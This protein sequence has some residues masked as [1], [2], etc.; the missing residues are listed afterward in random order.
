[1]S[2]IVMPPNFSNKQNEYLG[3]MRQLRRDIKEMVTVVFLVL[4]AFY[5][6]LL[7]QK[8]R[9]NQSLKIINA[10]LQFKQQRQANIHDPS[11]MTSKIYPVTH[12]PEG[13][14]CKDG[15]L[16]AMADN[17]SDLECNQVKYSRSQIRFLCGNT[18]SKPPARSQN[19]F[20]I[21]YGA[22]VYV[23]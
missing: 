2:A 3:E 5:C 13:C 21:F 7:V 12:I 18:T 16:V 22:N 4:L 23:V 1:M 11:T 15:E 10:N 6:V 9:T 17:N 20:P 14:E 8:E 19:H